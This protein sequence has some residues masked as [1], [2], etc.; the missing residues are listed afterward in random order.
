MRWWPRSIRWQMVAGFVLLEAISMGLFTLFLVGHQMKGYRDR[1]QVRLSYEVTSMARQVQEALTQNRPGWVELSV[2]MMGEG[3][4]VAESKVTDKSGKVL[5]AGPD[6]T[7]LPALEKEELRQIP[8]VRHE[9]PHAFFLAGGRIE[10][11]R[12]I[13]FNDQLWGYAWVESDNTWFKSQLRSILYDAAAFAATWTV[14]SVLLVLLMFTAISRPLRVLH[15]GT[16]VLMRSPE[17]VKCFPLPVVV[18]NELGDL[19]V[20]FNRM[21]ASIA[22]Q[23]AGL[24]DTLSLL[25]SMLA[26]APIGLV[27]FDRDGRFVRVNQIF[28]SLTGVAPNR[29][30]GRSIPDLLP[31]PIAVQLERLVRQVFDERQTVRNLEF[32]APENENG[33]SSNWLVSAYPVLTTPEQVRW[34]GVIVIDTTDRKRAEEAMRKAEKLAVAGRLAASIA[35]EINNPLEAITNLLFLAHGASSEDSPEQTYLAMAER[36]LQRISEI[37]QQTLR[38]YRQSTLPS[39][40]KLADLLDSVLSLYHGRLGSLNLHVERRYDP[41]IDLFCFAGEIRQVFANLVGNAIDASSRNGCLAVRARR[42]HD[43]KTPQRSG[44][45]FTVADNGTG[46]EPALCKRVFEA[47]YTTKEATGTGL[48]LWISREIVEKHRGSIHMRSRVASPGRS[49]GTVFQ[50]FIPDL[51][52]NTNPSAPAARK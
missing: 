15:G 41:E 7:S 28:A 17:G 33:R 47:F 25:D 24:N 31:Q 23:R 12:A 8:R 20:A 48:G 14:A 5:F 19:I 50:F 39:R 52:E 3:P 40:A 11:V 21:V 9:E 4:A 26:N 46:M 51:P 22:E 35:H 18:Q 27:F 49:S 37:T 42:A 43:G 1:S 34:V 10:A 2:A 6:V 36:E 45:L 30:L 44:V 13:Y 38:F 29:H 16:R 32:N